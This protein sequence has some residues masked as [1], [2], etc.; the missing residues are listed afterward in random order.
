MYFSPFH[1]SITRKFIV[2]N[3]PF[4]RYDLSIRQV[5]ETQLEISAMALSSLS[6][7]SALSSVDFVSVSH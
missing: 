6:T 7:W 3:F 2:A 4:R 1:V 5:M